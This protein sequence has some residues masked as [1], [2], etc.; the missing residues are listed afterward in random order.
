ML[1]LHFLY[2][3]LKERRADQLLKIPSEWYIGAERKEYRKI[4]KYLSKYNQLPPPPSSQPIDYEDH[5]FEYFY[6]SLRGR[7]LLRLLQNLK[8]V[9]A[10]EENVDVV[11]SEFFRQYEENMMRGDG[12]FVVTPENFGEKVFQ[13]IEEMRRKKVAGLLGYPT[14]Y[15]SLD[16]VTGGYV[17]GDLFVYVARMKMG[18]TMYVLNSVLNLLKN[19][20][21]VLFISMEM[22]FE[23]VSRRLLALHFKNPNFILQSRIVSSFIDK[24]IKEVS[25]PFYY[26]NGAIFSDIVDIVS[27][28][29]VYKPDVVVID[30]AYLLPLRANSKSEWERATI[31][32]R[33]LRN[34]A[35]KSGVPFIAT[36]QL[37]RQAVRAKEVETEHIAYTDAIAQSASVVIGIAKG[38]DEKKKKFKILANREGPSD[39]QIE[40]NWDWQNLDFSE[41]GVVEEIDEIDEFGLALENE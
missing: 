17:R 38:D 25:F 20:I 32:V 8:T 22:P 31:I 24:Q 37:N 1:G 11:L 16:I 15:P 12:I 30:G 35:L 39:I 29:N 23:S 3:V 5:T 41:T 6:N 9:E 21:S 27:L 40:V 2:K 19:N 33:S 28:M 13:S 7:Y 18:K 14:G 34:I 4:M 26:V 10:N 36:Y